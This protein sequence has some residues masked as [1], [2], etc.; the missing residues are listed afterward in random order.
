MFHEMGIDIVTL[1]NNHTLDYGREALE[2][3]CMTLDEAGIR[4]VG[5]GNDLNRAKQLEVME[6][7]GKKIG[8]LG[9][10][11]VVPYG[12]PSNRIKIQIKKDISTYVPTATKRKPY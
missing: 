2:D 10:S 5:A 3:S 12:E 9:A 11:R 1:A 4:Y 8:F 6:V 7:Q